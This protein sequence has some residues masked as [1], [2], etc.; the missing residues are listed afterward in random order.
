MFF[1]ICTGGRYKICEKLQ[2]LFDLDNEKFSAL[3]RNAS[4]GT[5]LSLMEARNRDRINGM[6]RI[7]D[8][9]PA[10]RSGSGPDGFRSGF[11]EF[12]RILPNFTEFYRISGISIGYQMRPKSLHFTVSF[13]FD[14]FANNL[15]ATV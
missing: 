6:N 9:T 4:E 11:T 12:Y 15:S 8:E 2:T 7:L 5:T 3:H 10:D 14:L 1:G 13:D